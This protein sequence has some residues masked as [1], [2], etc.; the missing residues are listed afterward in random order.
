M[1]F[2]QLLVSGRFWLAASVPGIGVIAFLERDLASLPFLACVFAMLFLTALLLSRRIMFSIAA[3]WS[4][5]AVIA[6][7]SLTKRQ[8]TGLVL[9][10]FDAYFYQRNLA[11]VSFVAESYALPVALCFVLLFAGLGMSVAIYRMAPRTTLTRVQIGAMLVALLPAIY[12]SFPA[13]AHDESYYSK[14]H[15]AS[16]F[17]VSLKDAGTMF[18]K[19]ELE[20]RLTSMTFDDR[21]AGQPVC[22]PEGSRSDVVVALMESAMP[23]GIYPELKAPAHLHDSFAGADGRTRT[24][25]V[26]TYGGGTWISMVGLLTGLP[27]TKFG[28]LRP[29]LTLYLQGRARHSLANVLKQCGYK[30]AAISPM[31]YHFVNE[32]PFM[33]SI[34]I[35]DFRDWRAIGAS[36]KHERD[37][38]YL[39]AASDYIEEHRR[40]D[41]RPLFL[42]VTTMAP[43]SPYDYRLDPEAKLDGEPY[44]NGPAM[45]EYLRRLAMQRQDFGEFTNR[46]RDNGKGRP[47]IVLEFG[48]HQPVITRPLAESR[49]PNAIAN[50]NSKAYSTYYNIHAIHTRLKKPMPDVQVLDIAFL[51]ATLLDVAGLP[52]D[53]VLKAQL[54]LRDGCAGAFALCPDTARIERHLKALS[55][56]GFLDLAGSP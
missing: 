17:F 15:I 6:A 55:N 32:G 26:E 19:P 36:S 39:K 7:I 51:G 5:I 40:T 29:Y 49:D 25:R 10:A 14:F 50:W 16:S 35:D 31:P 42:F 11:A 44:G 3:S 1:R 45:D 43:H 8:F 23:P 18:G 52:Q 27:A 41:G 24:L 38:V 37:K 22:G 46:L 28:W 48:D 34:G 2:L 21:F 53:D 30:T 9:H 12:L 33:A 54:A 20:S 4:I 13:Q 56:S 47:T